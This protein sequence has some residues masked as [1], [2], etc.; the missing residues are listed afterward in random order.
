LSPSALLAAELRVKKVVLSE[1]KKD[2]TTH[3]HPDQ[4]REC[5]DDGDNI[6]VC[7]VSDAVRSS[8]VSQL[9]RQLVEELKII[10]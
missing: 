9:I 1:R 7:S 5:T 10:D 2:S 6:G 4:E 8:T 3:L